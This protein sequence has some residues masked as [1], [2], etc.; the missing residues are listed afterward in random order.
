MYVLHG[1]GG[2]KALATKKPMVGRAA[3]AHFVIAV[4]RTVS[5]GGTFE[6]IELN[7]APGLLAKRGGRAVAAILID[8]DGE[9]I[10]SIFAIA[11]PDKLNA[12]AAAR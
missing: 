10:R 8:T 7:G 12:L 3:V 1:D 4:T 6:E 2:G 9:R 5:P 11:N